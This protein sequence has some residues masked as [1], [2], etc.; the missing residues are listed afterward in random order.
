[1]MEKIDH[2][3]EAEEGRARDA[4]LGVLGER[5]RDVRKAAGLTQKQVAEA[6]GVAP[7]YITMVETGA[8]NLTVWSLAKLAESLGVDM[9]RFFPAP[10]GSPGGYSPAGI[11]GIR[12]VLDRLV[13]NNEAQSR[14]LDLLRGELAKAA[15]QPSQGS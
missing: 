15:D 10:E 11:E 1:M 6:V 4:F 5:V 7:S 12:T 14:E 8:Q 3:R 2:D 9:S 13:A